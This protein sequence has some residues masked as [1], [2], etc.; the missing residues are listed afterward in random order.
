ML[1]EEASRYHT[2]GFFVP[3][4]DGNESD[5]GLIDRIVLRLYDTTWIY[6]PLPDCFPDSFGPIE[7]PP[8]WPLEHM[9]VDEPGT[10]DRESS[11]I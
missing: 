9:I 1:T 10:S 7:T 2:H 5:R 6:H 8:C 3:Q 11:W 4:N